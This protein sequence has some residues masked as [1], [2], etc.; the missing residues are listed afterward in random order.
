L[1]LNIKLLVQ[2]YVVVLLEKSCNKCRVPRST[3][4]FWVG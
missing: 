3:L 4:V 2:Y 1:F